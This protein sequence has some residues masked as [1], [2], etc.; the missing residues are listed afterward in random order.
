MPVNLCVSYDPQNLSPELYFGSTNARK[1]NPSGR[2]LAEIVG[3]NPA[4]G[5]DVCLL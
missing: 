3:S 4:R 1:T 5:M 2:S